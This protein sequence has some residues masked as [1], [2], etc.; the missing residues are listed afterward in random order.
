M[1]EADGRPWRWFAWIG[2]DR[3]DVLE[4]LRGESAIRPGDNV[5]DPDRRLTVTELRALAE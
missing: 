2:E 4:V 5:G 3:G 1:L